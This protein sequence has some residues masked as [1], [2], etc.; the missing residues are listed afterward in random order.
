MPVL[1]SDGNVRRRRSVPF[2]HE[3][4]YDAYVECLPTCY[5][6]G[7][8]PRYPPITGGEHVYAKALAGRLR[9]TPDAD[10]TVGDRA[11][12]LSS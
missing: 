1:A 10:S 9:H 3:G 11:G 4:N 6:P 7:N 5:G 2:F 8:P 12:A